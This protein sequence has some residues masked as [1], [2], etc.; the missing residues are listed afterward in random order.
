PTDVGQIRG[1]HVHFR[2]GPAVTQGFA[3]A[4]VSDILDKVADRTTMLVVVVRLL[5]QLGQ[6]AR[7]ILIGP[8]R[9]HHDIVTLIAV[10]LGSQRI[11]DQRAVNPQLFLEAGMAVVRVGAVLFDLEAVFVHSVRRDAGEGVAGD[12]R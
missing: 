5:F 11:D 8:V 3:P 4:L 12:A 7:R 1:A 2:P 6:Y 9:E 10:G